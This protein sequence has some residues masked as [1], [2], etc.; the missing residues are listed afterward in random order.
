MLCN[1]LNVLIAQNNKVFSASDPLPG[2][3]DVG[4]TTKPT[5]FY[6]VIPCV[7]SVEARTF[8]VFSCSHVLLSNERTQPET[9]V[10][11]PDCLGPVSLGLNP[12]SATT[13]ELC[14]FGQIVDTVSSSVK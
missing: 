14:D 6:L 4:K 13:N 5:F 10:V 12:S 9:Q 3:P 7:C 1:V 11:Q 2:S 8:S